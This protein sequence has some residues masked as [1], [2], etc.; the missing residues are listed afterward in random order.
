M[1]S[2]RRRLFS[3]NNRTRLMLTLGLAVVLPAA[4]L[5]YFNFRHLD[6][7]KRD[8][9]IEGL[10]HRD[11][12]YVLEISEKKINQKAYGLVED[13]KAE[14]PS[15]DDDDAAKTRK[16]DMVLAKNPY[17]AHV[18]LYDRDKGF[19]FRSQPREMEDKAFREEHEIMSESYKAW[20]S[21]ESKTL[22]EGT[23][24]KTRQITCYTGPTKRNG[25]E[26]YM[27]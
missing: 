18:F 15:A 7:I 24:R 12:Q 25:A 13:A 26:A 21:L 2:K 3:G 6:D 9:K 27:T 1:K 5:I 23:L 17:L 22:F 20:F 14:F 16:L 11:F 8:K 19:V 4:T 10:I